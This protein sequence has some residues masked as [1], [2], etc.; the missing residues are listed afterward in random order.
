[1]FNDSTEIIVKESVMLRTSNDII[2]CNFM[3][4]ELLPEVKQLLQGPDKQDYFY[5][6]PVSLIGRN[7]LGSWW[8]ILEG[9]MELA[10]VEKR[11]MLARA[12][13]FWAK[14][15]WTLTTAYFIA[16]WDDGI[17]IAKKYEKCTIEKGEITTLVDNGFE[18]LEIQ[19]LLIVLEE[20]GITKIPKEWRSNRPDHFL[21]KAIL[22]K[23]L[24]KA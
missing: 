3:T 4:T 11:K 16:I 23:K 6:E 21:S 17:V 22:V 13:K 19:Q 24:K 20:L 2:L 9:N 14:D 18:R 10:E 7:G 1:M 12:K 15:P 5:G 8:N